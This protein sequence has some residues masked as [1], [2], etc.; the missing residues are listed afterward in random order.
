M[1]TTCTAVIAA[2]SLSAGVLVAQDRNDAQQ[3][4]HLQSLAKMCKALP[5]YSTRIGYDAA[6]DAFDCIRIPDRLAQFAPPL[7]HPLKE[8]K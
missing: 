4:E 7:A 5:G 1:N 6:R 3:R 8:P 2:I